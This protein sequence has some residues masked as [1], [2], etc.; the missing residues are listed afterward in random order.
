MS[1]DL[2]QFFTRPDRVQPKFYNTYVVIALVAYLVISSQVFLT[3]FYYFSGNVNLISFP[4]L[5]ICIWLVILVLNNAGR[6]IWAV[7]VI[8]LSV[9]FM[10]MGQIIL[11]GWEA[12]FQYHLIALMAILMLYPHPNL[13]L[14]IFS[15]LI[16]LFSFIAVYYYML[17][18]KTVGTSLNSNTY[19]INAVLSMIAISSINFYFRT[20]IADLVDRLNGSANT[21]LLTGLMNRRRMSHELDRH[22]N[23]QDRMDHSNSLILIDID[24]FKDINDTY[25][26]SAGDAV[27]K[28]FAQILKKRLRESDLISRWGGEEFLILA[29]FTDI[30]NASQLAETLRKSV[31]EAVFTY[32]KQTIDIKITA[33]VT[34][35]IS[36]KPIV[37]SL[38]RVDKL[39]YQGKT[40]G[41]NRVVTRAA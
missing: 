31:E 3:A 4:V 37:E 5:T 39:L 2:G 33:G 28:Q 16:I 22:C 25:G 15:S 11:F 26:H 1:F 32:E 27:L 23:L 12:G 7:A 17:D 24:H 13:K 36:S 8:A 21:D 9:Y 18:T 40:D 30:T 20:N 29:P 14:P 38:K 10:A 19:L 6:H 35:L 41:R 34:E